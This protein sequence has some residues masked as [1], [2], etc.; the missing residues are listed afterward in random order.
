MPSITKDPGVMDRALV[1]QT[2]VFSQDETGGKVETWIN[3]ASI[4][5]QVINMRSGE[6]IAAGAERTHAMVQ[7]RI[8]WRAITEGDNRITY[9]GRDWNITAIDEEGR[10]DRLILTCESIQATT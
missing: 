5:A 1:L 10:R 3:T 9:Q 4:W 2:R 7:F 8:R 6:K